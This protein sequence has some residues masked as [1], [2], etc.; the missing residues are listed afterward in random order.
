MEVKF[1][2]EKNPFP[3]TMLQAILSCLAALAIGLFLGN[4]LGAFFGTDDDVIN[5]SNYTDR[6]GAI[7]TVF[8]DGDQLDSYST[9][10][11]KFQR[12]EGLKLY[13]S[14]NRDHILARW[15][16]ELVP[17]EDFL[18]EVAGTK[19]D[20]DPDMTETSLRQ[21]LLEMMNTADA[22]YGVETAAG[23]PID[24]V[25]LRNVAVRDGVVYYYLYYDE[26]GFAG[27]AFDP[28]G[29]HL[30]DTDGAL[31]LTKTAGGVYEWFITYDMGD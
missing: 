4:A 9:T 6:M 20:G 13:T 15:N 19:V 1:P 8:T 31:P 25:Y 14:R 24:D 26:A 29:T 27:L 7:R 30:Q 28:G 17:E 23:K 12:M 16:G 18:T 3:K 21:S 10:A 22:L 11:L 5:T 2:E